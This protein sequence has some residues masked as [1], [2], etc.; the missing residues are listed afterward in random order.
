LRRSL[1]DGLDRQG[2]DRPGRVPEVDLTDA[3]G[4]L[5]DG[6]ASI[7]AAFRVEFCARRR[8][9]AEPHV[10]FRRSVPFSS[11][12]RRF[13]LARSTISSPRPLSTAFTIQS[14]NPLTWAAVIVGGTDSSCRLTTVS[15]S[16]GPSCRR[17]CSIIGLT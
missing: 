12:R 14:V 16:A 4:F 17:A 13:T 5:E 10:S 9:S 2:E 7:V 11:Y 15:T 1:Q 6:A 3:E 8:W